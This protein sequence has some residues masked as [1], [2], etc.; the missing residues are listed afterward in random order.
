MH[1][2]AFS[3]TSH[4]YIEEIMYEYCIAFE[5]RVATALKLRSGRNIKIMPDQAQNAIFDPAP[6]APAATTPDLHRLRGCE[7]GDDLTESEEA[8]DIVK[9]S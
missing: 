7:M 5:L 1:P 3:I 4:V 9:G 2:C 8:T 6:S